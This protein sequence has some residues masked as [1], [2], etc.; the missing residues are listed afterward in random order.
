MFSIQNMQ[1]DKTV[2]EEIELL[3]GEPKL[4]N[5]GLLDLPLLSPTDLEF[6]STETIAEGVTETAPPPPRNNLKT[7][8]LP[9]KRPHSTSIKRS[10][11]RQKASLSAHEKLRQ[12]RKNEEA[13]NKY[14]FTRNPRFRTELNYLSK[15]EYNHWNIVFWDSNRQ[16]FTLE[17]PTLGYQ[18]IVVPIRAIS[19][20]I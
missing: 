18:R 14:I 3:T 1:T 10:H 13:A 15:R 11:K 4:D 16:E 2:A 8:P 7:T 9:T 5:S 12:Q 19:A 6:L 17:N 20:F